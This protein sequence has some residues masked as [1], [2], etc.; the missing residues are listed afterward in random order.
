MNPVLKEIKDTAIRIRLA[1][2]EAEDLE[3]AE[4]HTNSE[5]STM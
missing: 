3:G 2:K 5:D 4:V 1:L